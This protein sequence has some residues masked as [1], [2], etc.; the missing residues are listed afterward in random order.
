M[1]YAKV[2]H[3]M[4]VD[5]FNEGTKGQATGKLAGGLNNASSGVVDAELSNSIQSYI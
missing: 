1:Y 2:N 3:L 4:V 5:S